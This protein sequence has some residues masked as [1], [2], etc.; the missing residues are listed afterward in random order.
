MCEALIRPMNVYTRMLKICRERE[1]ESE[2]E[3]ERGGGYACVCAV[4]HSALTIKKRL[5][6]YLCCCCEVNILSSMTISKYFLRK[7]FKTFFLS[8]NLTTYFNI[9]TSMVKEF[10]ILVRFIHFVCA[11]NKKQKKNKNHEQFWNKEQLL[12]HSD[13]LCTDNEM[14]RLGEILILAS[15]MYWEY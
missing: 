2:S 10:S 5:E 6:L 13:I 7:P 9:E 11:K 12:K 15:L 4:C 1:R 8:Q 3:R 14:V